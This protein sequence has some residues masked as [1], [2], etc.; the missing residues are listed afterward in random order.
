VDVDITYE[1]SGISRD[2]SGTYE[3]F[4][5]VKS[6][7]PAQ[8]VITRLELSE[9]LEGDMKSRFEALRNVRISVRAYCSEANKEAIIN[10]LRGDF[11][12][13]CFEA[14]LD[15]E[16]V[17]DL[18]FD[19]IRE[20]AGD[21]AYFEAMKSLLRYEDYIYPQ[22]VDPL[23]DACDRRDYAAVIAISKKELLK[24][25]NPESK[26]FPLLQIVDA[27]I[28][29]RQFDD[30]ALTLKEARGIL[31]SIHEPF[32][33]YYQFWMEHEYTLEMKRGDYPKAMA[34]LDKFVE[35]CA[36]VHTNNP[37]EISSIFDK[38]SRDAE[39]MGHKEMAEIYRNRAEAYQNQ[40]VDFLDCSWE[41]M[42][43]KDGEWVAESQC[44]Y[45]S[46][47]EQNEEGKAQGTEERE[48]IL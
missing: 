38:A 34:L 33:P 23:L 17:L 47:D 36:R 22:S 3:I 16:C 46:I 37:L 26:V 30:A 14:N 11:L 45:G 18:L 42:Y 2:R 24:N 28:H 27:H 40:K 41:G 44:R 19:F 15:I 1:L 31:D 29:L 43:L 6:F 12:N 32:Y 35:L 8:P 9:F 7:K 21:T 48:G 4:V 20:R 13:M 25:E 39:C 10:H 5:K